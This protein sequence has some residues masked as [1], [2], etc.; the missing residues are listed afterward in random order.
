VIVSHEHKF[1]F[2]K[3]RKTAG[4]SVELAL[5][6]LCGPNDI[7]TNLL[8]EDEAL[9]ASTGGRPAQN[10]RVHSWWRSS[11]PLHRRRW[12]RQVAQDYGYYSHIKAKDARALIN[13]EQ[14]WRSYFKFAFDR[15][16]WDRQVSAYHFRFRRSS[17]PPS[18]AE[19]I[20]W[21]RRAKLDNYDIYSHDG[22]VCVDFLGRFENLQK[23]FQAALRLIGVHFDEELPRA[24]ANV[25]K[26]EIHYR[27]Y[28]DGRTREIVGDWY[29][30]EIKAF[31]YEF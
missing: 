22:A 7:I 19:H 4:T 14:I 30:R 5:R 18:F 16:P 27:D 23:D 2:L 26:N 17:C 24:K 3:T 13:D 9:S 8:D 15:N 29:Q 31:A 11:R 12:L 28:Y 6:R 1:I 10:W 21:D 25:R 20:Y